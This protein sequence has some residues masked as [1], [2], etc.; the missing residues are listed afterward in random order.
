M[1]TIEKS[2]AEEQIVA[3]QRRNMRILEEKET[4]RQEKAEKVAHLR[5]LRLAKA[6]AEKKA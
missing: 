6:A 2:R 1:F 3:T 5:N 4:I